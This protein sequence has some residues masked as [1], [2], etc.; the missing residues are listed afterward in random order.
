M[1]K[2]DHVDAIW[3]R[4]LLASVAREQGL[5]RPAIT[6]RSCSRFQCGTLRA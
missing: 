2:A 1:M 4:A 3:L 5:D 6:G